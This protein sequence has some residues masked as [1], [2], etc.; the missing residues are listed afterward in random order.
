MRQWVADEL[1]LFDKGFLFT[2]KEVMLRPVAT[3]ESYLS[4][5]TVRYANPY[6]LLII[7]LSLFALLI[8]VA[9]PS[10]NVSSLLDEWP[11][12]WSMDSFS[13]FMEN[14]PQ[15]LV[16]NVFFYFAFTQPLWSLFGWLF[17]RKRGFNYVEH[18]IAWS[19]FSCS[20]LTWILVVVAPVVVLVTTGGLPEEALFVLLG[21]IVF[22]PIHLLAMTKK[23]FRES[24][25]ATIFKDLAGG[26]LGIIITMLFQFVVMTFVKIGYDAWVS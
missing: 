5:A 24:W 26:Y 13:Y 9:S 10:V 17:F 15:L 20:L 16:I 18:L 21:T 14:W 6:K 3:V 7:V 23:F 8:S 11:S 12:A 25:V 22:V 4:G 19:Y 2:V 1:F